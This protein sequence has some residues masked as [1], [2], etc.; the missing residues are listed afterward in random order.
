MSRGSW[1]FHDVFVDSGCT[2][3]GLLDEAFV[4]EHNIETELL[5]QAIP[6]HLA[7]N[8]P[9]SF[10][11]IT[12]KTIPLT[13]KIGSHTEKIQFFVTRPPYTITLGLP[14]LQRHNPTIDWEIMNLTFSD[15]CCSSSNQQIKSNQQ[16]KIKPYPISTNA[17]LEEKPTKSQFSSECHDINLITIDEF[18]S[19][20]EENDVEIYEMFLSQTVMESLLNEDSKFSD[21]CP[22]D[23]TVQLASVLTTHQYAKSTIQLDQEGIPLIFGDLSQVFKDLPLPPHRDYDLKVTLREGAQLPKPAR[24]I[25]LPPDELEILEKL[26]NEELRRKEIRPSES[27]TAA[28]VFFVK[29]PNGEKR[30]CVDY[31]PIN[32]ETINDGYPMPL[33]QDILDNLKGKKYFT[34]LDLPAAY[35]LVRIQKGYEWKLAFRCKFG[36]FEPTVMPFGFKGCPPAFQRFITAICDDFIKEGWLNVYLDNLLLADDEID[37]LNYNTR[38]VLRRLLE[39]HLY[40]RPSKCYF[41]V[42][43]IDALG[44]IVSEKGLEMNEEKVKAVRE[45]PL[46]T[47]KK[48]LHSFVQFCNFY[49]RFIRNFSSYTRLLHSA[50]QKTSDFE[51]DFTNNSEAIQLFND[52]KQLFTTAP[53][54]KFFDYNKQAIIESDA[55][56]YAIG[57]ILS[58]EHDGVI[59]PVAYYSRLLKKIGEINYMIHDKELLSIVESFK[60][61]RHYLLPAKDQPELL[62]IVINDH[63][64]LQYFMQNNNLNRRQM[65]WGHYLSEFNFKIIHRPGKTSGKPDALSRRWDYEALK[66]GLKEGNYLRLFENFREGAFESGFQYG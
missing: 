43:K 24:I 25:P 41:V 55:S 48:Q 52:L 20:K 22:A 47:T 2:A 18:E 14:W 15:N 13:L 42:T 29:K 1:N 31:R 21:A 51:K 62:T 34:Q 27:P 38:R 57:S 64:N 3:L 39:H 37:Q 8:L 32:D 56:D 63:A 9:A 17:L 7:D 44:F 46:P 36:I 45:W 54:L 33:I 6:V 61:W 59:H 5:P 4:I 35:H 16:L 53:I 40:V 19:I 60:T 65:T 58:Q 30:L 66:D 49:R 11:P 28:A 10:G 50:Y 23:Q 26:L 12:R